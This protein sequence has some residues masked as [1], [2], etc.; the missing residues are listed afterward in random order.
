MGIS[1]LLC[2]RNKERQAALFKKSAQ[3]LLLLWALETAGPTRAVNQSFLVTFFQ[4]SNGLL[5]G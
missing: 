4:K 2:Y 5:R 3:K 1:P